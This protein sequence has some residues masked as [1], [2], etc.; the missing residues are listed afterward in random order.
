MERVRAQQSKVTHRG[1]L[2]IQPG[3]GGGGIESSSIFTLNIG[4]TSIFGEGTLSL[5]YRQ[6]FVCSLSTKDLVKCFLHTIGLLP[7]PNKVMFDVNRCRNWGTLEDSPT[8]AVILPPLPTPP[9]LHH[10]HHPSSSSSSPGD[11]HSTCGFWYW[12]DVSNAKCYKGNGIIFTP[13]THRHH[14]SVESWSQF[15]FKLE[16]C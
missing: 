13:G 4:T 2:S 11:P 9:R 15:M 14:W 16:L 6:A 10:W 1:T 8:L 7:S 5:L 12:E 3:R